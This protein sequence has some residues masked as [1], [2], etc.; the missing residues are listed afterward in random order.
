MTKYADDTFLMIGSSNIHTTAEEFGNIQALAMKNNLQINA[1]KTKEM[2]IFRRR[3]KSVTYPRTPDPWGRACD[4][5]EGSGGCNFLSSYNGGSPRPT[6]LL[7]CLFHLCPTTFEVTWPQ[8]TTAS[9]GCQSDNGC[10]AAIRLTGLVGLATAEDKS[11]MERLLG[12]LRRGGY[13]PADFPPVETLAVAADHQ[14]FVSI[15]SNPYHVLRR[16]SHEKEACDY[17]LR[18]I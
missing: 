9:S 4:G 14:L 6:P 1:N 2:I 3:S 18:T 16:L 13:M 17:N 15:A 10:L 11:R 7:L 8:S 12:R 5:L